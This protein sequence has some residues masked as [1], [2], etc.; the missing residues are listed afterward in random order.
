MEETGL[1]D[2]SSYGIYSYL[3]FLENMTTNNWELISQGLGVPI[4]HSFVLFAIGTRS[5]L[6]PM[7]VYQ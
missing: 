2:Y 6:I 7:S 4:S 1:T 5:I 3:T